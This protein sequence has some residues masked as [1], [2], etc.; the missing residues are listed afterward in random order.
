MYDSP[1]NDVFKVVIVDP[2]GLPGG[3][4]LGEPFK[5]VVARRWFGVS[6][7]DNAACS[8][9]MS[10]YNY[11]AVRSISIGMARDLL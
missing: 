9:P 6:L 10:K 1:G 2:N 8:M 7:A 5:A 3:V 11:S 4:V